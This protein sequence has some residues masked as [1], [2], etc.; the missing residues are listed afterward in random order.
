MG[1]CQCTGK[2]PRVVDHTTGETVCTGCGVVIDDAN[3]VSEVS[4]AEK[5]SGAAMVQGQFIASDQA[6]ASGGFFQNQVDSTRHTIH[7]TKERMEKLAGV[8]DI[9]PHITEEAMGTFRLALASHFVKGRKSQY[10]VSACLYL[11][12]RRNKTTHMLMDFAD[13]LYVNVFAIGSTYLQ[14]IK[15]L[16]YSKI[17]LIDPSLFI[18]RFVNK[19]NFP[20]EGGKRVAHDAARLV[21]RMGKDWLHEG[22]RPAGIA[23]ACVLLAA[24]MNNFRRSRAEIVHIAKVAEETV[25]RRLDEFSATSAGTLT[26]RDFRGTNIE[27]SADPPS[28]TKHRE[29][30]KK[31]AE[32]KE[33]EREALERGENPPDPLMDPALVKMAQ[34]IDAIEAGERRKL[35]RKLGVLFGDLGLDELFAPV[36]E[37]V[38]ST[39]EQPQ[40]AASDEKGPVNQD[41]NGVVS[42][43]ETKAAEAEA[44]SS[45]QSETEEHAEEG[46]I[47]QVEDV[48]Q[49]TGPTVNAD[50]IKTVKLIGKMEP[51][52]R[53]D[54]LD[55]LA[56]W[57]QEARDAM[58]RNEHPADIP[59][60]DAVKA[61]VDQLANSDVEHRRRMLKTVALLDDVERAAAARREGRLGTILEVEAVKIAEC[62]GGMEEEPREDMLNKLFEWIEADKAATAQDESPPDPL[63]D[64]SLTRL[65]HCAR[66]EEASEESKLAQEVEVNLLDPNLQ[67]AADTAE[68]EVDAARGPDGRILSTSQRFLQK[69]R[70]ERE[71][72]RK[73][74][75]E[76][77]GPEE[78]LLADGDDGAQA[79]S[80]EPESLSD[81]DDE[82]LESMILTER[83][84][85]IKQQVWMSLN[86]EYLMEQEQKRLR[87][88]QESN[89]GT[90][91]PQRK[92][93]RAPTKPKPQDPAN[94]E[95]PAK[96]TYEMLQ[97]KSSKKINYDAINTLFKKKSGRVEG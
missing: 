68:Q 10:V 25:Q 27:S 58:S 92:R 8:L 59:F 9:P 96:Q 28:F 39:E 76:S 80:A 70:Q 7:K 16:K 14:L 15:T 75:L 6:H 24:R 48:Q 93:R 21:Q 29:L 3:I 20:E 97:Q 90:A 40:I 17:P 62:V 60:T 88:E 85:E 79:A 41:P 35:L 72:K 49:P 63:N 84:S 77:P 12:C 18:Q 91:K 64:A 55:M 81:V 42:V 74:A 52:D 66:R 56:A 51:D 54:L 89:N 44:P 78:E 31:L 19:L 95:D 94:A 38:N 67:R 2:P 50:L 57:L 73:R 1:V 26:V 30:E 43:Q 82:E 5:P 37:G 33:A 36:P 11:A 23:A 34:E 86:R 87:A 22:R 65:L 71:E 83:E 4:F 32:L 45:D 53:Q 46:D 13:A 61:I 69:Y 47:S